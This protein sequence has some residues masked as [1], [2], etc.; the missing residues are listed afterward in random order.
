MKHKYGGQS[1]NTKFRTQNKQQNA[2]IFESEINSLG[3]LL[4]DLDCS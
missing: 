2:K 3:V 4:D 1:Y